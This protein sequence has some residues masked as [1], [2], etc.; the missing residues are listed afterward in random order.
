MY[1]NSL[2]LGIKNVIIKL[3][4]QFVY[5]K[6]INKQAKQSKTVVKIHESL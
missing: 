1:I 6:K 3:F 2:I 5:S 4:L